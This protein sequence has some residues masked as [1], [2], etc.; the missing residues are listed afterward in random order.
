MPK[1]KMKG[2]ILTI[3]QTLKNVVSSAVELETGGMLLN[4]KAMV[5]IQHTIIAMDHLQLDNENT[6]KSDRKLELTSSAIS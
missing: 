5:P 3:Y 2:P 1:P 4:G 6:L